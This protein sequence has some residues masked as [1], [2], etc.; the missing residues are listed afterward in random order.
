MR[1]A[2]DTSI[3]CL[4]I[5]T[6]SEIVKTIPLREQKAQ[7]Q[8]LCKAKYSVG[9]LAFLLYVDQSMSSIYAK[10]MLL[11]SCLTEEGIIYWLEFIN[12]TH[13]SINNARLN[14]KLNFKG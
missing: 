2:C 1:S 5:E 7:R 6:G 13:F 12:T 3:V 4:S 8:P 11:W 9:I 10:S 14:E